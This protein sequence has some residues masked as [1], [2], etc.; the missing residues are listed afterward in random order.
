[1]CE[2]RVVTCQGRGSTAE[3]THL[4]EAPLLFMV[5]MK[6]RRTFILR[7]V[8]LKKWKVFSTGTY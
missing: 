2:S 3:S 1:M 5:F 8:D 6:K 7:P 4:P